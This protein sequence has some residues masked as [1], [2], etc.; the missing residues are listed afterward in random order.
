MKRREF[1]RNATI[2]SLV[3]PEIISGISSC[4]QQS[5]LRLKNNFW[6]WG[7]TAGSHHE[8]DTFGLP[9]ENRMQPREGC[10]FFGI[11]KCLRVSMGSY[12][13]VPPFDAE[14]EKIKALKEVVWSAIGADNRHHNDQS[15]IDEVLRMAEKYSNVSGAVLDDFFSV[16]PA[17]HSVESVREM[18]SKLHDFSK[19]RLDLWLVWYTFQMNANIEEYLDSFDVI[20]MWTWNGS[21]LKNF[22]TNIRKFVE[23]THGKRRYIGVYMWNYGER[24]PLSVDEMKHQ[25]GGCYRWLKSK[26][27]ERVIFC[28]NAIADLGLEAVEYTR[29]WIHEIGNESA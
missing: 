21:D 20:T 10:K 19:R 28:S 23:K 25:L 7:Q 2:G 6:L 27:I 12:G 11:D 15:D 26:E 18:A 4:E 1:V 9:G 22:D 14:A 24:K 17:K 29:S 5:G 13:P 3:I 8:N 16:H